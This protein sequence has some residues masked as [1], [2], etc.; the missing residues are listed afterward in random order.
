M[1]RI[2]YGHTQ[3]HCI[4]DSG[5][6]ETDLNC[7]FMWQFTLYTSKY[8]LSF[9]VLQMCGATRMILDIACNT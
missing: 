3:K 7:G 6:T 1:V 9:Y 5:H 2:E 4:Q 8:T